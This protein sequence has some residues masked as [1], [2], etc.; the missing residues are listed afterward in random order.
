MPPAFVLSQDQTLK[1]ICRHYRHNGARPSHFHI[2]LERT[3]SRCGGD[4]QSPCK[5]PRRLR[6]PSIIL[7]CQRTFET[8]VPTPAQRSQLPA[9]GRVLRQPGTACQPTS[10]EF[11]KY[12]ERRF[13]KRRL[14]CLA[15]R[16]R[17]GIYRAKWAL[18]SSSGIRDGPTADRPTGLPPFDVTSL[19]AF[20]HRP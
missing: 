15:A 11:R 12:A 5:T 17:G 16:R 2:T 8:A 18:S 9:G 19:L 6:I 7:T 4:P 14:R 1:L 20:W 3:L 10:C 13:K